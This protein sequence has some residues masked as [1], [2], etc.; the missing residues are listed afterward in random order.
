MKVL[1][2]PKVRVYFKEL[3]QILYE[4]G[5]FGFEDAAIKYVDS[6]FNEINLFL[7]TK[8]SRKAPEY[9]DRYGNNMSYVSFK[10]NK[11]TQWY[12]FF[13][14]YNSKSEMIYLVLYN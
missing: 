11:T 5:Y 13:N 4:K 14:I 1:F 2:L 8:Y 7:P 3:A 12:V 6:L 9:F 10:K